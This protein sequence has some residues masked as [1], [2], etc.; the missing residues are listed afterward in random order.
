MIK[1]CL[2][3]WDKNREVLRE[4]YR[5]CTG[6]NDWEYTDVVTMTVECIL[7][8]GVDEYDDY[9]WDIKGISCIDNGDYQGTL[10]FLIPK[11]TYQPDESEYL[12]TYVDYGSC[13]G[14][15]TL[16]AIQS[17]GEYGNKTLTEQ[18]VIDF[19]QLSKDIITNM[20]RPYNKGW[21]HKDIFDTVE[22]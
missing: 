7:N 21:R 8:N 12:M 14:C 9:Y 22:T 6:W 13:S 5:T 19:M 4:A 3:Q 17:C 16:Q 10:L 2:R 20:I 1:Y 18:Q 11:N 15:D